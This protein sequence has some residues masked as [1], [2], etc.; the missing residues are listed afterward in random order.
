[1]QGKAE[2]EKAEDAALHRSRRE[3]AARRRFLTLLIHLY[4]VLRVYLKENTKEPVQHR[5]FCCAGEKR[6]CE[7]IENAST[8][9]AS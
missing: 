3:C 2:E 4:S 9:K 5:L 8:V 6:L 1:M 7:D